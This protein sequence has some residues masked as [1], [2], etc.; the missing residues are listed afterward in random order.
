MDRLRVTLLVDGNA[1]RTPS[2]MEQARQYA[3][4]IAQRL[5]S[6]PALVGEP[7]SSYEGELIFP[8]G[9]GIWDMFTVTFKCL[10][11]LPQVD[12]VR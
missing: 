4:R 10:L 6:D 2:P 5:E 1:V 7:G 9:Y 12:R 11:T 8:R 3:H